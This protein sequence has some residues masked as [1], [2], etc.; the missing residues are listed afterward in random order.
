MYINH[1]QLMQQK[2]QNKILINIYLQQ[3]SMNILYLNQQFKHIKFQLSYQ[4]MY[5]LLLH[6]LFYLFILYMKLNK[7]DNHYLLYMYL[8]HYYMF[9]AYILNSIHMVQIFHLIIMFNINLLFP[10]KNMM[11]L[12]QNILFQ[13]NLLYMLITINDIK[14]LLYKLQ[15]HL[16]TLYYDIM[17]HSNYIY[18]QYLMLPMDI[19]FNLMLYMNSS[20]LN[21]HFHFQLQY[22][23]SYIINIMYHQYKFYYLHLYIKLLYNFKDLHQYS[24]SIMYRLIIL[25]IMILSQLDKMLVKLYSQIHQL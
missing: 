1:E 9:L 25:Y 14:F 17:Y 7:N 16:N 10:L 19:M 4:N 3:N 12:N 2:H 20:Q 22:M 15:G 21:I 23:Y 6:I 13:F 5:F 11:L 24:N 18:H 8:V